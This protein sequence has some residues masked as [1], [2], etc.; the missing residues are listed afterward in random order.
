MSWLTM[1]RNM[2]IGL[3]LLAGLLS[4]CGSGGGGPSSPPGS[5]PGVLLHSPSGADVPANAV[6]S[7]IFSKPMNATAF[8]STNVI[9][10]ANGSPVAGA[11]FFNAATNSV[12]FAPTPPLSHNTTYTVTIKAGVMDTSGIAMVNDYTWS[13]TTTKSGSVDDSFGGGGGTGGSG[14]GGGSGIGAVAVTTQVSSEGSSEARAVAFQQDGKIVVAGSACGSKDSTTGKCTN[15]DFAL[16]RYTA[17]GV[18]D[19]NFGNAGI[20]ITDIGQHDMAHAMAIDSQDRIVVAGFV[21]DGS[22]NNDFALARYNPDGSLDISFDTDGIVTTDFGGNDVSYALALDS[23]N[24][25]IVAGFSGT[26]GAGQAYIFSD[27]AETKEIIFGTNLTQAKFAVARYSANGTPDTTFNANGKVTTS[28]GI[29][30][31][32]SIARAIALQHGK[33]VVAGYAGD[34][35]N[36]NFALARYEPNGTLDSSFGSNGAVTTTI[37]SGKNS[38]ALAIAIQQDGNIVAAGNVESDSGNTD[39]ALAR[40]N[41]D[42]NLDTSFSADG[43]T[44]TRPGQGGKASAYAIALQGDGKIVAVGTASNGTDNDFAMVRYR[45]DNGSIDNGFG[46]GGVVLTPVRSGEDVAFAVVPQQS[47]DGK[48]RLIMAGRSRNAKTGYF[49]FALVRYWQ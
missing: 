27:S 18:P 3:I 21:G 48:L 46:W 33:I 20:A 45:N 2:G 12:V 22:G 8:T 17:D 11:L 14:G 16:V 6:I 15:W 34:G 26:T 32:I 23:N 47:V 36:S 10:T 38:G 41:A 39:F 24:N 5:A 35:S 7:A 4:A 44:T 25:I 40:Y 1:R 29:G 31:N 42:G 49:D 9:V 19:T 13:F 28:I 30:S 37:A 43:K